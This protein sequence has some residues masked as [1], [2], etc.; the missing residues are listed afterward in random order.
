MTIPKSQFKNVHAQKCGKSF[1]WKGVIGYKG[2]NRHLGQ[3]PLTPEGERAANG[4]V[5]L[6]RNN[7]PA[8]DCIEALRTGKVSEE[9][10]L[11]L[12]E[13]LKMKT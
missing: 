13:A 2:I 6:F 12:M 11:K 9:Y 7:L 5:T 10:K 1:R 4:A 3:F 8:I